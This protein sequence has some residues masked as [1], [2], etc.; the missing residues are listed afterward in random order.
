[1]AERYTTRSA[2]RSSSLKKK[3]KTLLAFFTLSLL[4]LI[5]I[6][7]IYCLVIF[8]QVSKTLPS[9]ME[10]GNFQPSEGTKIL[11]SDGSIMAVLATEN[12]RPVKLQSVDKD[13]VIATIATEDSRF[14]DHKGV[15][16]HGVARAI[17]KN[18]AGGEMREGASTITQQLA[19]NINELGLTREKKFRRKVAE[20]ILA[21]RIE[22][23]FGKDEILE[24]YLNQI[25]YG[26]GA[27]GVEA[28]ARTYFHKSSKKLTLG[29]AAMLAGL[30]QS[31][32]KFSEDLEAAYKR[33]DWVLQRMVDTGKITALERDQA[34]AEK[35][36]IYPA[37]FSGTRIY[38]APY[39]VNYV[40]QQL[41]HEYGP[42]AVYR[43]WRIYT[44]IDARIQKAGEETLR[45][46]VRSNSDLTNQGALVSIDPRTGEVR[47]MVG[48]VDFKKSKYNIVMQGSR[49][50]GSAFKPIVYAAAFDTDTCTLNS[51]Y[52]DDPYLPN[53]HSPTPWAPKNYKGKYTHGQMRVLTAIQHS[54]NTVAVKVALDA[55]L[56]TV[57]DYAHKLGITADIPPYA[58]IAL[59]AT[60]V[61][62]I[63]L[64]SAYSTFANNG[65]RA[66]PY[67]IVKVLD[68]KGELIEDHR[69]HVHEAVLKPN[70]IKQMNEA[71]QEA[72][73]HGTGTAAAAVP[74]A[75]GK[76]GTT[77]D[78]RDAWFA[79]YTP[80][81]CTVVWVGREVRNKK[82]VAVKYLEM[83]GATGG[84][85][86]A[87]IWKDFMLKAVPI[88]QAVNKIRKMAVAAPPDK[89]IDLDEQKQKPDDKKL[90]EGAALPAN[91][92]TVPGATETSTTPGEATGLTSAGTLPTGPT[93]SN[94]VINPPVTSGPGGL[95]AAPPSPGSISP[96]NSLDPPS[97]R[98]GR[99]GDI[100]PRTNEPS[101]RLSTPA[102]PRTDP[103]DEMVTVSL[104]ADTMGRA[105]E[106]C[107]SSVERRMRRR[108]APRAC[109]AHR[110]P[111]GEDR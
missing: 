82:G 58:P 45:T 75:H 103:G 27:Y 85:I 56:S 93:T 70:T 60:A 104:C 81:L 62:P 73:L 3:I 10:I 40:M 105:R 26:N 6:A 31:P 24:L 54:I 76:T 80:E 39:V 5:A 71:L 94:P 61:R 97:S 98:S 11:Y 47:A 107:P 17:Y 29:E 95:P 8:V 96:G 69:P 2:R 35:L 37:N 19:R 63:E 53:Y 41:M 100:R 86:C 90:P 79:G 9:L 4:S 7:V 67:V 64:C 59:G 66:E 92:T 33:R 83:P 36:K 49:Q 43:G 89:E 25:Y 78:N 106:W 65:K 91:T 34:K 46:G 51:T 77:S 38:G 57:I 50:P 74:N 72:V 12:R 28:A 108:D 48:G 84:R 55:G 109:R 14:Y 23:T 32:S 20:A 110:A 99:S 18:V 30:P 22:Q 68:N 111:P 101:G 88:Q 15:D 16:L 44:S 52:R 21:M 42:D 1:M 13:L 87:P 102:V